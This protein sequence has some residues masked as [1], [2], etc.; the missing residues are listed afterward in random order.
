MEKSLYTDYRRLE[1]T[2]WWF[3]GRQKIIAQLLQDK[4]ISRPIRNALDIGCGTGFCTSLVIPMADSVSC[5]EMADEMIEVLEKNGQ[6]RIVQ[7]EWP[8][9]ALDQ[10]FSLVTMFDSLEH[11]KDDRAALKKVESVL[12]PGGVLLLTVPAYSFLWSEHDDISHHYR[13]YTK[14]QMRAAISGSTGLT[15]LRLTYF[16]TFFFVPIVLFRLIKN[17]FGLHTKVSDVLTMPKMLNGAMSWLFALERIPLRWFNFPFGISLACIAQKKRS[18][19][20]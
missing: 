15:I 14:E 11:I 8:D 10:T 19:A 3:V 2:H 5:V 1:E 7:G 18:D 13:R 9:V 6:L 12:E 20:H 4:T 17:A 16:S